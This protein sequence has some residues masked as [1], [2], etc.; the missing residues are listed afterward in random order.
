MVERSTLMRVAIAA[1]VGTMAAISSLVIPSRAAA[2]GACHADCVHQTLL[3]FHEAWYEAQ[4]SIPPGEELQ[5]EWKTLLGWLRAEARKLTY[6]R[7]EI[8]VEGDVANWHVEALS[9]CDFLR[10]VGT[11]QGVEMRSQ[12]PD[13]WKGSPEEVGPPQSLVEISPLRHYYDCSGRR[14]N[15]RFPPT[16]SEPKAHAC[17][18]KGAALETFNL[19]HWAKPGNDP[20]AWVEEVKASRYSAEEETDRL[21]RVIVDTG[22]AFGW[23]DWLILPKTTELSP[24]PGRGYRFHYCGKHVLSMR[25]KR[26]RLTEMICPWRK[27][28]P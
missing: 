17:S 1:T 23:R 7:T 6:G 14:L 9:R 3:Q 19:H 15:P 21:Y 25:K 2:H 12:R 11:P 10:L 22:Y 8:R 18:F 24:M 16:Y 13:G 27:P 20:F 26:A 28:W 4:L 5:A